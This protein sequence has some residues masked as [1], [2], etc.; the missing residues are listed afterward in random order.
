[1]VTVY[2]SILFPML[3]RWIKFSQY[4]EAF[5]VTKQQNDVSRKSIDRGLILI[6][7]PLKSS[8]DQTLPTS[9]L[10]NKSK[11]K[12]QTLTKEIKRLTEKRDDC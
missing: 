6:D 9:H 12:R 7:S 1:M 11:T 4:P 5:S 10:D 3:F 2:L 8:G